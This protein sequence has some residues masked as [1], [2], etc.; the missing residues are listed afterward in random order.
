MTA[1][2]M[3]LNDKQP[4]CMKKM[5]LLVLFLH[6]LCVLQILHARKIVVTQMV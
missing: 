1:N 3:N 2:I 5:Q 6:E 4:F